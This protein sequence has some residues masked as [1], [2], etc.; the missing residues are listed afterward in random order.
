MNP[1]SQTSPLQVRNTVK[2]V[3]ACV[4]AIEGE[5]LTINSATHAAPL[6]VRK[7]SNRVLESME[8]ERAALEV[9]GSGKPPP[10]FGHADPLLSRYGA[11]FLTE[12]HTRGCH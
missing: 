1:A 4:V 11:R 9:V 7:A 10:R 6:Q 12:I 5:A 3:R 8:S 2:R